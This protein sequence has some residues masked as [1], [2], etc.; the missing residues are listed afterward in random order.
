M[1]GLVLSEGSAV[2]YPG[3]G[4]R[5]DSGRAHICVVVDI[6]RTNGD[7]ML[8]PIC[9]YFEACDKT[10]V[11]GPTDGWNQIKKKSYAAYFFIKRV[12]SRAITSR[13]HAGEIT[14]LGKIPDNIYQNIRSGI[15]V[16]RETEQKYIKFFREKINTNPNRR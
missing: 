2:L 3:T 1:N 6:D 4:P 16:S 7:V 12:G 8:I 13:L 10:C 14:H 15:L 5:A 9:S 11:I